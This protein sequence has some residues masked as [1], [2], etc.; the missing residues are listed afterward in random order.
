MYFEVNVADPV[1][2]NVRSEPPPH[3][4]PG[5]LRVSSSTIKHHHLIPESESGCAI[6]L[7]DDRVEVRILQTRCLPPRAVC[8][9][10]ADV[11]GGMS[12]DTI[13]LIVVYI[14]EIK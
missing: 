4:L 2:D 5:C 14:N 9:V 6:S 3:V 7:R 13:I 11:R 12:W 8:V 1:E 10:Q